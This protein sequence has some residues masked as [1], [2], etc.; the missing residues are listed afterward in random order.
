M[1]FFKWFRKKSLETRGAH[2][3]LQSIYDEMNV[4]YFEGNVHLPIN[5]FGTWEPRAKRKVLL[6]SYDLDRQC[7]KINRL[8]DHPHVPRFYVAFVVYHEILHHLYPPI[9]NKKKRSIH[10]PAF[11][12]MERQ[13]HDY[14]KAKDYAK[15]SKQMWFKK[16]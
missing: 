12:K 10:H 1:K 5:W 7:I 11:K 2:H 3:D 6:G 13:F 15:Q 16:S 14:E 9:M 4:L 8:L